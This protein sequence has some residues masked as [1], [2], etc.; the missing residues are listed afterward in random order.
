MELYV[1]QALGG[2]LPILKRGTNA[3]SVVINSRHTTTSYSYTLNV[4]IQ[5]YMKRKI[6]LLLLFICIQSIHVDGRVRIKR[7]GPD[8][9]TEEQKQKDQEDGRAI[10]ILGAIIIGGIVVW[11][12]MRNK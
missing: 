1:K 11:G 6:L 5:I 9:R 2:H 4:F 3:L 10:G 8:Y 7:V 12:K